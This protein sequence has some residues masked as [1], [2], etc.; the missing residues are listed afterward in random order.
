MERT[1]GELGRGMETML[2]N[3]KQKNRG[4]RCV[5]A[6]V[7]GKQL[8]KTIGGQQA[9]KLVRAIERATNGVIMCGTNSETKRD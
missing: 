8:E 3:Q 7:Q 1:G 2:T 9:L 4:I 5:E 6:D